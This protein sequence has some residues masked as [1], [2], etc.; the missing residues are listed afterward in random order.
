VNGTVLHVPVMCCHSLCSTAILNLKTVVLDQVS[1]TVLC[2]LA[3]V[4]ATPAVPGLH[5]GLLLRALGWRD[6][7]MHILAIVQCC[8]LRALINSLSWINTATSIWTSGACCEVM[9]VSMKLLAGLP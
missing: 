6:F 5:P 3:A 8:L 2:L 4:P 9:G 7:I 1:E